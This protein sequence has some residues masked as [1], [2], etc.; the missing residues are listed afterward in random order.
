MDKKLEKELADK[1]YESTAAGTV[2]LGKLTEKQLIELDLITEKNLKTEDKL[3]E[4]V[5]C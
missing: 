3:C 4:E 2:I 5:E 1:R